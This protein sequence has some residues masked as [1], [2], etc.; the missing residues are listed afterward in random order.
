MNSLLAP[1]L[2][3]ISNSAAAISSLDFASSKIFTNALLRP[4]EIV[5]L[6]RDT[7]VQERALFTVP[8]SGYNRQPE[9]AAAQ[10]RR[11]NTAVHSVLGGDM[12]EKLRRGGA[13][14]AAG[15]GVAGEVDFE[16][17]L[18]GVEALIR[19][20]YKPDADEKIQTARDRFEILVESISNYEALVEAQRSQLDLLKHRVDYKDEELLAPPL[21][22]GP[23]E[24]ELE[25]LIEQEEQLIVEKL[26]RKEATEKRIKIID[27][28]LRACNQ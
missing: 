6:I 14:S 4:C 17:L 11:R 23:T 13:Y 21:E 8:S 22:E 27:S 24:S 1:H 3:Q 2:G 18:V 12:I 28:K 16:H 5:S 19:V 25:E 26:L 7:D 15:G 20:Y 10:A 9:V